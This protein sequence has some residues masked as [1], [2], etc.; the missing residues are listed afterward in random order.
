MDKSDCGL[1]LLILIAVLVM[2]WLGGTSFAMNEP[3]F[4]PI[5][6]YN[7]DVR[8]FIEGTITYSDGSYYNGEVDLYASDERF[9]DIVN[10][11]NGSYNSTRTF[12][13][14]QLIRINAGGESFVI[15]LPYYLEDQNAEVYEVRTLVIVIP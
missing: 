12:R 2:M 8:V 9:H 10:A 14:G 6:V 7:S 15:F 3:S 4:A 5:A 1:P 11:T 13:I